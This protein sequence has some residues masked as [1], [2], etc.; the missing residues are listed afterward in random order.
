MLRLWRM[1]LFGATRRRRRRYLRG[2]RLEM[3]VERYRG[4]EIELVDDFLF[5]ANRE[6]RLPPLAHLPGHDYFC[7][8][9]PIVRERK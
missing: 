2:L 8:R 7:L 3:L 5:Q 4:G 6:V 9:V 1:L